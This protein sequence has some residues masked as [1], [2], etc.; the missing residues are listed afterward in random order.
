MVLV[1]YMPALAVLCCASCAVGTPLCFFTPACACTALCA[2]TAA[3]VGCAVST[4]RTL[5]S[6]CLAV[7]PALFHHSLR[8]HLC[9]GQLC[10]RCVC[11]AAFMPCAVCAAAPFS[12]FAPL[13]SLAALSPG[14]PLPGEGARPCFV[15]R[16]DCGLD[17][18]TG[19]RGCC[20]T[21]KGMLFYIA[22]SDMACL[23]PARMLLYLNW[24]A[25]CSHRSGSVTLIPGVSRG[26]QAMH[27]LTPRS[28]SCRFFA[29][30]QVLPL[31]CHRRRCR[32]EL[33]ESGWRK[34]RLGHLGYEV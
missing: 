7:P 17:A 27:A 10:C 19:P 31:L 26:A 30:R 21:S 32:A 28:T 29:A 2:Y 5:S 25:R 13:P 6:P 12:A 23:R 11:T 20:C 8:L 22:T 9:L 33:S 16:H 14:A 24:H 3:F 1:A 15:A 34:S 4:S 18:C